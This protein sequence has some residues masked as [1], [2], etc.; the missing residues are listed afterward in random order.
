MENA[1][2]QPFRILSDSL[3]RLRCLS[4]GVFY[5][6]REVSSVEIAGVC[7]DRG[8]RFVK[9]LDFCGE[10]LVEACAQEILPESPYLLVCKVH[11]RNGRIRLSCRSARRL[12]IFEELF[13]W[14]E[15][16]SLRRGLRYN[17]NRY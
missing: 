5:G 14:A 11:A 4:G 7:I 3:G 9:I 6:R 15:A 10:V 13:F 1:A 17:G 12:G 16:V 8:N 2:E